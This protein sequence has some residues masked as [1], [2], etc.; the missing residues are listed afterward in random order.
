MRGQ[1]SRA[2]VG[3]APPGGGAPGEPLMQP[4][5]AKPA[6]GAWIIR[7]EAAKRALALGFSPAAEALVRGRLDP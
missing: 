6:P 5:E 4:G 7:E 1:L 3:L 2:V